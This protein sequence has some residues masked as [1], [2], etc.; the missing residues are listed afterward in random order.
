MKYIFFRT[1]YLFTDLVSTPNV[2]NNFSPSQC[3]A[4]YLHVRFSIILFYL[5]LFNFSRALLFAQLK[6]LYPVLNIVLSAQQ[7][8][9]PLFYVAHQLCKHS[10][11]FVCGLILVVCQLFCLIFVVFFHIILFSK[12]LVR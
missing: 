9:C 1:Q 4:S 5:F 8:V 10:I 12:T 3:F 2:S 11:Y 6:V 7:I